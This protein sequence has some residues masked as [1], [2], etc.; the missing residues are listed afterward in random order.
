VSR[1]A[2]LRAAAAAAVALAIGLLFATGAVSGTWS[3]FNAETQ[4]T[5]NAYAGGWIPPATG[6]SASAAG[7]GA[8]L[9]WT[10]GYS[11]TAGTPGNHVN[12]QELWSVDG[13]TG[14]SASC[15]TYALDATM[16]AATTA[17]YTD[18]T[19]TSGHWWC[20][21]LFEKSDVTWISPV[22]VFTSL[23]VGLVPT[24]VSYSGGGSI[25]NGT[26]ITVNYNQTMTFSTANTRVCIFSGTIILG[27]ASACTASGNTAIFGKLVGGASNKSLI[28]GTSTFG[29]SGT[30]TLTVTIG[31]CPT[32]GSPKVPATMSGSAAY[33]AAGATMTSS[34]GGVSQ[35]TL[36][37]NS[38]CTP[39]L[40]Y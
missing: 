5:G 28:C 6:L 7:N 12:G 33:N 38:L 16:A 19:G 25:T 1:K 27:D 31:G 2:R 18:A 29:G 9:A 30:S 22:A 10:S 17:S 4:N 36:A 34:T 23:Q 20:Y 21:E 3:L 26:T 11:A 32:T 24:S 37:T 35:C 13:G 8:S 14:T 39:S 40:T 15:G